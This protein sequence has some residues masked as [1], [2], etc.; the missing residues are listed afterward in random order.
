MINKMRISSFL[1]GV[2]ILIS[3][4][5]IKN[6]E[7][8]ECL[9]NSYS[10]TYPQENNQI[11][12]IYLNDI[13]T[14]SSSIIVITKL[15]FEALYYSKNLFKSQFKSKDIYLQLNP[16]AHSEDFPISSINSLISNKLVWSRINIED[17]RANT[18]TLFYTKEYPDK[19]IVYNPTN[20][21]I[22]NIL[23]LDEELNTK[24]N[25]SKCNW[26]KPN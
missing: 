12:Y 6:Y 2:I 21:C 23:D 14:D 26:C 10:S 4:H 11:L 13:W 18:D 15:D 24:L 1:I 25:V 5:K 9:I 16:S 3:C 22:L 19:Q 17:V 8:L 7:L 20:N